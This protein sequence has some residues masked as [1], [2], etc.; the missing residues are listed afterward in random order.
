MCYSSYQIIEG[1]NKCNIFSKCQFAYVRLFDQCGKITIIVEHFISRL[2]II[3]YG[4]INLD[5][6]AIIYKY[7]YMLFL[8]LDLFIFIFKKLSCKF[9]CRLIL[10][11]SK[12]F[13]KY[14]CFVKGL[15]P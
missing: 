7:Y 6:D 2:I 3:M 13:L 5:R 10:F 11:V 12:E 14:L 8:Y 15:I 1:Y 4:C 9:L